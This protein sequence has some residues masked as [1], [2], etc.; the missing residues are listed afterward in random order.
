MSLVINSYIRSQFFRFPSGSV[1]KPQ[2]YTSEVRSLR[3]GDRIPTSNDAKP[4]ITAKT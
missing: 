2:A 3:E 1:S 4:G